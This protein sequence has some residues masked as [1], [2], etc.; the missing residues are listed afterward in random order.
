MHVKNI[1]KV[2]IWPF[3][4]FKIHFTNLT[5]IQLIL[6]VTILRD[7]PTRVKK[8]QRKSFHQHFC[9]YSKNYLILENHGKIAKLRPS[10]FTCIAESLLGY[11]VHRSALY[12]MRNLQEYIHLPSTKLKKIVKSNDDVI[13]CDFQLFSGSVQK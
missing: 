9:I 11:L 7:I 13:A 3:L 5:I 8:K 1:V 2:S 12:S 4:P 6:S 10:I